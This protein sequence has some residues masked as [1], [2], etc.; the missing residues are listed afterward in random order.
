MRAK[1]FERS[2]TP[3]VPPIFSED[4]I[5][6]NSWLAGFIDGD[7]YFYVEKEGHCCNLQLKQAEWNIHLLELLKSKLG[8]GIY[9]VKET[10]NTYVY[11]LAQRDAMINLAH[12]INGYVRT[13]SRS[14]QFKNMCQVYNI[15]HIEPI[16]LKP[17]SN[18]FAGFV[19]ADGSIFLN[20]KKAK[21]SGSSASIRIEISAK[22]ESDL[23]EFHKTFGGNLGYN[24]AASCHTWTIQATKDVMF[25]EQSFGQNLKSNKLIRSSLIRLFYQLRE[26]NAYKTESPF[27]KDWQKLMTDWYNN[28]AD[29]YR[30]D[31]TGVPYTLKARN[32]KDVKEGE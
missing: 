5:K 20:N 23:S 10:K 4:D 6:F 29:I 11:H 8:G 3:L 1:K 31:C 25:A 15:T 2:D 21:E 18:Y 28:G 12:C 22:F 30:K 26:K 7:G 19:D 27:L 32:A 17:S 16:E 13:T 9:R 24:K 14:S